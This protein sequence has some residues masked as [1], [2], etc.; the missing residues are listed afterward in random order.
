GAEAAE[1]PPPG[2]D[3]RQL[4]DRGL[5]EAP[6]RGGLLTDEPVGQGGGGRAVDDPLG[7][8][9]PGSDGGE[10]GEDLAVVAEHGIRQPS[11]R[12]IAGSAERGG[13]C[14]TGHWG[15]WRTL[16]RGPFAAGAMRLA[17]YFSQRNMR[18]T[19]G[20]ITVGLG[21]SDGPDSRPAVDRA[22]RASLAHSRR[23]R[24]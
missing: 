14:S 24:G 10:V 13:V 16:V 23:R 9:D 20:R 2:N 8:Q 12:R 17:I 19:T 6:F 7:D 4:G 15:N 11:W 3:R 22:A 18:A 5:F 21:S 1:G